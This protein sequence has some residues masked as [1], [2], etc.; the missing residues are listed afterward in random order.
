MNLSKLPEAKTRFTSQIDIFFEL[1]PATIIGITGSNGKSTT[2]CLTAH[3]LRD[4]QT[5]E[6]RRQ[7]TDNKRYGNVFL[8]GNIGNEPF[9]CLLEKIRNEDLVVMEISSFQLEELALIQK[10]HRRSHF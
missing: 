5:T 9:L 2:T 7:R 8:T 4:I 6:D 3:L 1:C 10:A